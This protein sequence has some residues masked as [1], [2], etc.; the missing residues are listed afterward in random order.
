MQM[1][2]VH[3]YHHQAKK[4]KQF[5]KQKIIDKNLLT[6]FRIKSPI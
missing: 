1:Q 4:E 2:I 5:F 3:L 6:N